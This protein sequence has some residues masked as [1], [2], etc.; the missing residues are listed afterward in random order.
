MNAQTMNKIPHLILIALMAT[1]LG[2]AG[3]SYPEEFAGQ[4]IQPLE[5]VSLAPAFQGADV[6]RTQ[7]L[8]WEHEGNRAIRVGDWKLVS[9]HPRSW[10]LYGG[11]SIRSFALRK[12]TQ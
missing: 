7:P 2:L 1:C 10:E 9:K 6:P 5:G 3:A 4:K 8:F 12:A 11:V